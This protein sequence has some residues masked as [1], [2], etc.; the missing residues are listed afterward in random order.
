MLLQRLREYADE[1]LQL[2]PRLYNRVAVRYLITLD[3]KGRC[4]T[5]R[6]EDLAEERNR[7]GLPL[8]VP[9]VRRTSKVRPLLLADR[10]AYTLGY[11]TPGKSATRTKVV[12]AAYIELLSRCAV[13]TNEP[14]VMAVLA[15]LQ[16]GPL[17][18]LEL[19][20]D[21]DPA[22]LI[23]FQ[24]GFGREAVRPV[25]LLSV[26][27]FW[28]QEHE[29]PDDAPMMQCLVC[30]QV[31]PALSRMQG[32]IKGVPG[33]QSSGTTLVSANAAAFESYGLERSL[34]A[35]TCSDCG[36]RTTKALNALLT[37]RI[38]V[39]RYTIGDTVFVFWTKQ[40]QGF[41]FWTL[42][43]QP[44]PEQVRDLLRS[45]YSGEQPA[46]NPAF[47]VAVLTANIGRVV[48]RDWLDTTLGSIK[49]GLA[50]WFIHQRLVGYDGIIQRPLGLYALAAAT[51]RDPSTDLKPATAQTLLRAALTGRPLPL[52]LLAP[53]LQRIRAEQTVSRSHAALVKL[54][55]SSWDELEPPAT[56]YSKEDYMVQLEPDVPNVAYQC[57]RLL[58]VLERT[59]NLALGNPKAGIVNRYYGAASTSPAT[60]TPSLIR[61]A[62]TAHLPKLVR[63]Y[64]TAAYRIQQTLEEVMVQIP[65][66]GFPTT[67]NL[68]EQGLVALGY[69]HQRAAERA[70]A[71]AARQRTNKQPNYE[72]EQQ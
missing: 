3:A 53:V 55:L 46:V 20:D 30:G 21:F 64:P 9:Q 5:G 62:T 25:D 71:K 45:V 54:L 29:P 42:L 33:G 59:Q 51:V 22:G 34:V 41:N 12:N 19:P 37:N 43:D 57:G 15:F 31:R 63:D 58:A 69:Y 10:A 16:N 8:L 27:A 52:A 67:L 65:S 4:I 60:V 61:L 68:R 48:V 7:R 14:A 35:P 17:Q 28:A 50:Q 6:L 49:R 72:G 18:Q 36:E 38:E 24:V 1:R 39:S 66:T 32:A 70:Q 44:H 13:S 40:S 2:P 23:T 47:Y 26:Q 56:Y 11:S